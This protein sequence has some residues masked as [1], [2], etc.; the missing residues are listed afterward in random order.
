MREIQI[1]DTYA[2]EGE[3]LQLP[4]CIAAHKTCKRNR[5]WVTGRTCPFETMVADSLV[6]RDK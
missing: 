2:R 1:K 4:E 6:I 3:N 5:L